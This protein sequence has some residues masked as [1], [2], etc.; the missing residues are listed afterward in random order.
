MS[1]P[2]GSALAGR[3]RRSRGRSRAGPGTGRARQVEG[4]RRGARAG[5]RPRRPHAADAGERAEDAGTGTGR[6][7][8]AARRAPEARPP[9]ATETAE[10]VEEVQPTTSARYDVTRS[11][12]V[13]TGVAARPVDRSPARRA[14][15]SRRCRDPPVRARRSAPLCRDARRDARDPRREGEAALVAVLARPLRSEADAASSPPHPSAPRDTADW[16]AS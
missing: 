6:G 13:N 7:R 10:A 2:T 8:T 11:P 9:Q 15:A 1:R 16:A 12:V 5:A 3:P 4:D 14:G